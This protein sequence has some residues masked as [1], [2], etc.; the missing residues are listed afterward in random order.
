[1]NQ[2]ADSPIDP[3]DSLKLKLPEP[4]ISVEDVWAGDVLNRSQTA[5]KLTGLIRNQ[6]DSFVV[7]IHGYW[8]SGKTFLLRRWQKDLESKGFNAIYFNAWEDDFCDDPLLAILGQL[9]EHFKGSPLKALAARIAK[10][11]IPLLQKNLVNVLGKSIGLT[12]EVDGQE[13]NARDL[14]QE[15]VQQRATKDELKKHLAVMSAKVVGE[16]GF[17]L[18]FIIDELDRCRPTFAVELLERVKHIFDVPN[19]VFVF[20]VNRD[21]LCVSLESIYGKIDA[22]IYLRR[23][24]DMEFNLPEANSV[25]F[26]KHLIQKYQ[27]DKHFDELSK[28]ANHRIHTVEFSHLQDFLPTFWAQLGFSLRDID[29]CV[30]S[31]ALTGRNLGIRYYMH[32]WLLGLLITLKLSNPTLYRQFVEKSRYGSEVI[33]YVNEMLS[34]QEIDRGSQYMLMGMEAVVYQAESGNGGF[35][36]NAPSALNQLVLLKNGKELTHPEYLSKITKREGAQRANELIQMVG[37]NRTLGFSHSITSQV[38]RLI[39]LQ[40]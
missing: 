8:G 33:D 17:P 6:S 3:R 26:G 37:S 14:L 34:H 38:V 24:Y 9:S 40:Q 16:T 32:P 22:D 23:F 12:L 13:Q 21:E 20:G 29:Y 25:V 4:T 5:A 1:M 15:Y 2:E 18:V 28:I 10:T 35:D 36:P 7:S 11:A 27:L 39:D 30:R 31:I 19:L